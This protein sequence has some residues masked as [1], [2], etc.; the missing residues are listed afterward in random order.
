MDNKLKILQHN[1]LSW[2]QIRRNEPN[3]VYKTEDPDII[4]L[5]AH[6]RPDTSIIKLH[7]YQEYQNN[8]TQNEH[9]GS[10]IAIKTNIK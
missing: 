5:N 2:T 6:G 7:G 9:D 4:L 3:N 1:M 10:A 8:F